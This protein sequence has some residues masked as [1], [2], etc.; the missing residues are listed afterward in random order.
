[1]VEELNAILT[2]VRVPGEVRDFSPKVNF[3]CRLSCGVR[4]PLPPR[5]VAE[6]I[7][8]CAHVKNTELWQ[9]HIYVIIYIYIYI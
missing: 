6:C 5:E 9:S 7:T 1:M 4:A 3:Q 2:R 8:I